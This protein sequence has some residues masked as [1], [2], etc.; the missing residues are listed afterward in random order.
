[1]SA[2]KKVN[3]SSPR[4]LAAG[5]RN[6][7][8]VCPGE[9]DGERTDPARRSKRPPSNSKAS[10]DSPLTPAPQG[11]DGVV[12]RPSAPRI[13]HPSISRHL[14]AT[15]FADAVPVFLIGLSMRKDGN[16]EKSSS[17]QTEFQ[18][19]AWELEL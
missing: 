4:A 5:E 9:A 10:V 6:C 7:A 19:E 2:R 12:Y 1:M 11:T 8:A 18:N 15:F 13:G 17:K 16:F 3:Q 14:G